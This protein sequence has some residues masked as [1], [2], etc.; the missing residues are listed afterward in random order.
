MRESIRP[1]EQLAITL[2]FL[3]TGDSYASL[4]FLFKRSRSSV[5]NI[6]PEIS[7]TLYK[8]VKDEFLKVL[9]KMAATEE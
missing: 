2:R 9:V 1:G 5:C 7:T 8:A 4:M 6:V 3:A